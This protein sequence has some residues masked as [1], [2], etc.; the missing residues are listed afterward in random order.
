MKG[1]NWPIGKEHSILQIEVGELAHS[2]H[3]FT[4]REHWVNAACFV[5]LGRA[6]LQ[7]RRLAKS[8]GVRFHDLYRAAAAVARAHGIPVLP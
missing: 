1:Y 3:P 7:D 8:Q 6:S 4:L 5:M 2:A